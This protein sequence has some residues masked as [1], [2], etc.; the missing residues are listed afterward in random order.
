MAIPEPRSMMMLSDA[1]FT[2]DKPQV[3]ASDQSSLTKPFINKVFLKMIAASIYIPKDN[4][5]R[6]RGD[7][8]HFISAEEQTIGVADGVGGWI[9]SGIDG[10]EY[11]R[12]LMFNSV[13]AL[14]KQT[15]RWRTR[16]PKRVLQDA[17]ITPTHKDPPPPASSHFP[18]TGYSLRTSGTLGTTK[19]N[20]S[21]AEEIEVEVEAG[22]IVV[23]GTDGLFD[24]MH[25]SEILEIVRRGTT[26]GRKDS[27]M[28]QCCNMANLAL[29]NSFD[30]PGKLTMMGRFILLTQDNPSK[31]RGETL[32]SSPKVPQVIGVADGVG[33]WAKKGI[34]AASTHELMRN[35]ADAIKGHRPSDVDPKQVLLEAF[36]KTVLGSSTACI[37]SPW[38]RHPP[39]KLGDGSSW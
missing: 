3:T 29:Y 13:L 33:G 8:A 28:E 38:R 2:C 18:A 24:N 6:P 9:K 37:I 21:V 27:L 5:K 39:G 4:P 7:D 17:S 32:I 1:R 35:A 22:D 31:P 36:L 14:H 10:G 23:V 12:Q 25:A 30:R 20:P 19:D 34:G 26:E 15:K 16:K 11:A